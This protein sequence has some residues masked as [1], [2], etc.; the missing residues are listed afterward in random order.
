MFTNVSNY[1]KALIISAM[2]IFG[3]IVETIITALIWPIIDAWSLIPIACFIAIFLWFSFII[4]DKNYD[5]GESLTKAVAYAAII[6][7]TL[8]LAIWGLTVLI[9]ALGLSH[10]PQLEI[11]PTGKTTLNT[12]NCI[13]CDQINSVTGTED[14]P[15]KVLIDGQ[16]SYLASEDSIIL[17]TSEYNPRNGSN[18]FQVDTN[19]GY[20]FSPPSMCVDLKTIIPMIQE[21]YPG[22]KI[23]HL[24]LTNEASCQINIYNNLPPLASETNIFIA[25]I[26]KFIFCFH[27]GFYLFYIL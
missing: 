17:L 20:N 7:L 19:G 1:S 14:C 16:T 21:K 27:R 13:V 8:F 5:S 12:Y 15:S 2:W 26:G 25:P 23:I 18:D 3:I 24:T 9:P 10:P 6:L 11:I 4:G 22:K